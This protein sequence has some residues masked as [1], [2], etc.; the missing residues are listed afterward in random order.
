MKRLQ[1]FT[2][3]M[4]Y[5]IKHSDRALAQLDAIYAHIAGENPEA[6][7]KIVAEIRASINTL[8]DFPALGRPTDEK[9]IHRLVLAVRPYIAFYTI[10]RGDLVYIVQVLHG[11]QNRN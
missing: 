2:L 11:K 9:N 10:K 4:G 5:K 8:V 1:L 6:A 3:S 7:N